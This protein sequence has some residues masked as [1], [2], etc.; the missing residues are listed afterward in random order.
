[1]GRDR[2]TE[3]YSSVPERITEPYLIPPLEKSR[4]QARRRQASVVPVP[5]A[6]ARRPFAR[7]LAVTGLLVVGAVIVLSTDLFGIGSLVRNL[8]GAG[9]PAAG[10]PASDDT[11]VIADPTASPTPTP[12]P[13]WEKPDAEAFVA[14]DQA[15]LDGILADPAAHA[16]EYLSAFAIVRQAADFPT[17]SAPGQIA[18]FVALSAGQPA[19]SAEFPT[20]H[21][22]LVAPEGLGIGPGVGQGAPEAAI[23]T[24]DVLRVQL[25]V[26]PVGE[27][28]VSVYNEPSPGR[29]PELRLL[30]AERVEYHELILDVTVGEIAW[31]GDL[32]VLPIQVRNS[33]AQPMEYSLRLVAV[34]PDGDVAASTTARSDVI[35]AGGTG[36]A[37]VELHGTL[38]D[39][40]TF[41]IESV[42]RYAS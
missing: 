8:A 31:D 29:Y 37:D 23:A 25:M 26:P 41:R 1:M 5:A 40:V 11:V 22:V 38:P 7:F 6:S 4:N 2:F 15:T 18:Y 9:D 27:K 30:G 10:E 21:T 42:S 20:D 14:V 3:T 16:G 12:I 17:A 24:G 32:P 13:T 34:L 36:D 39:G 33:A 19:R 28:D 35:P